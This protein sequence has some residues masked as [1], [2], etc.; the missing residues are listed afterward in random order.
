MQYLENDPLNVLT[1]VVDRILDR[2]MFLKNIK[3]FSTYAYAQFNISGLQTIKVPPFLSPLCLPF[4]SPLCLPRAVIPMQRVGVSV[5]RQRARALVE[6]ESEQRFHRGGLW[7]RQSYPKTG[8]SCA[9]YVPK[10]DLFFA[11]FYAL[12]I[13]HFAWPRKRAFSW[14]FQR[15]LD[16]WWSPFSGANPSGKLALR[17]FPPIFFSTSSCLFGT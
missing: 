13:C 2:N 7:T 16:T 5:L 10:N 3:L 4:V 1:L 14:V 17:W 11:I 8:G 12:A 15:K 6:N 9:I